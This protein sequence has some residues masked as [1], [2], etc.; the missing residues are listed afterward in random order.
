M[1]LW[2][3]GPENRSVLGKFLAYARSVLCKVAC[4]D[5]HSVKL[6]KK[7]I[8]ANQISVM[9]IMYPAMVLFICLSNVVHTDYI[10]EL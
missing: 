5:K 10:F 9:I 4:N 6:I 2:I 8:K 1:V 7:T 3:V